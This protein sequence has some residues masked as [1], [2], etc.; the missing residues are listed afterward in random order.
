MK[1]MTE[2][3]KLF[4]GNRFIRRMAAL[5]LTSRELNNQLREYTYCFCCWRIAVGNVINI[6]LIKSPLQ[7][8]F[9]PV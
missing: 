1:C 2:Q 7:A 4:I 3:R 8:L 5:C 9:L 6:V